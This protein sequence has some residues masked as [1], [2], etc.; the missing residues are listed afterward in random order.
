MRIAPASEAPVSRITPASSRKTTRMLTPRLPTRRLVAWNSAS[1]V[2]PPCACR[3]AELQACVPPPGPELTPSVPAARASVTE[4]NTQIM[5]VRRGRR[6]GSTGRSS[7]NP[8]ATTSVTGAS[9]RAR[10][11]TH[12]S[13]TARPCPARPPSQPPYSTNPMNRPTAAS[14]RPSTSRPRWSSAGRCPS[15]RK[16]G[17]LTP[18]RARTPPRRRD[19]ARVGARRLAAGVRVLPRLRVAAIQRNFDADPP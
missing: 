15:P 1:P 12:P 8:P 2:T 5:P 14:A 7:S 11:S 10:P 3:K 19:P 17:N 16:L 13:A 6:V 4:A 9:T 18:L